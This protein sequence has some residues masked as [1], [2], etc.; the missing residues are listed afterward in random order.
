MI[1]RPTP[2]SAAATVITR[3]TI[4]CPDKDP[5]SLAKAIKAKFAAFSIISIDIK[6]TRTFLLIKNPKTP[7]EKS[8]P[9]KS[10]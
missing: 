2:A 4:T 3:N 7:I 1:A 6:T 10:R 8:I 5:N 9:L